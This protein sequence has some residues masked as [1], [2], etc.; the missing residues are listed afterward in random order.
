MMIV[1]TSAA[2]AIVAH[3]PILLQLRMSPTLNHNYRQSVVGNEDMGVSYCF[4][5]GK[6]HTTSD[7]EIVVRHQSKEDREEK[8]MQGDT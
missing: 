3:L 5:L 2:R 6:N 8:E 4:N 7:A 1:G